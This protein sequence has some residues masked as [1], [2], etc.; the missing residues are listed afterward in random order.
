[1]YFL[2]HF[3][4][5]RPR[6]ALPGTAPPWSPDFPHRA[7]GPRAT[8]AAR[9]SDRLAWDHVGSPA[10]PVKERAAGESAESPIR[11]LSTLE[12]LSGAEVYKTFGAARFDLQ[13][14]LYQVGW[15]FGC[16]HDQEMTGPGRLTLPIS[17][18]GE[19]EL[20][21]MP[22]NAIVRQIMPKA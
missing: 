16:W 19:A 22:A 6:R 7:G 13:P 5:G 18:P 15:A 1:V 12:V 4:W 17:H 11:T 9:P 2:W 10:P 14:G 3:P 20:V 8:G 21:P